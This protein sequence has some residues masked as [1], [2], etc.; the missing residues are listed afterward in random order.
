MPHYYHS[1]QNNLQRFITYFLILLTVGILCFLGIL[2]LNNMS[3]STAQASGLSSQTIVDLIN[4][5]RA[6]AS[7]KPLQANA[8]LAAAAYTKAQDM[9][10]Q[11]YF[12]HYRPSDN[13]RGLIFIADQGYT[14]QSAGENLAVYFDTELELVNGWMQ[15]PTHRKNILNGDFVET[16]VGVVAGQY[17]GFDTYFVVQFFASPKEATEVET[18]PKSTNSPNSDAPTPSQPEPEPQAPDEAADSMNDTDS[19]RQPASVDLGV[20]ADDGGASESLTDEEI[21]ELVNQLRDAFQE[22]D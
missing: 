22:L 19:S 1:S 14:Y 6:Q 4:Q 8:K 5:H 21:D 2:S 10:D 9:A 18:A 17:Q 20:N 16:G 11:G 13:K 3:K 7:Q 12:A 15:S